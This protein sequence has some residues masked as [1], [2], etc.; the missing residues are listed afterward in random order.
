MNHATPNRS[1]YMAVAALLI[2]CF[3]PASFTNFFA[4]R[5]GEL[6]IPLSAPLHKLSRVV[7][8]VPD[9]LDPEDP[10][11]VLLKTENE[12][13]RIRI[14]QMEA[15]AAVMA[16]QLER[17]Q[18]LRA[19][20]P[21]FRYVTASRVAESAGGKSALFKVGLGSLSGVPVGAY[22]LYQ[23]Y[24][25]VGR[26]AEVTPR[27]AVITPITSRDFG[28][29]TALVLPDDGAFDKSV[30]CSLEPAGDGTLIGDVGRRAEHDLPAVKVGQR[31]VYHDPE[32]GQLNTGPL[33]G[34]IESVTPKDKG[35]LFDTIVVRPRYRLNE[36]GA[37]DLRIPRRGSSDGGGN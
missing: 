15:R 16:E 29:I 33:I 28:P 11:L 25:L 21:S 32:P 34:F 19:I 7:R 35:P 26:V 12:Q 6:T 37:V 8:A 27:S 1:F 14:I 13:Q 10:Q 31:V 18:G 36:I 9:R 24:Q 5:L 20:D 2:A 23:G 22:A 3:L 4:G 30:R 17:L